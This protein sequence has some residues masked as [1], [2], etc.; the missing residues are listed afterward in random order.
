[1]NSWTT[2]ETRYN[3]NRWQGVLNYQGDRHFPSMGMSFHS[4]PTD[5]QI[6][7]I[8]GVETATPST[9][10]SKLGSVIRKGPEWY[11]EEMTSLDEY[12]DRFYRMARLFRFSS[13]MA[14]LMRTGGT[15][16]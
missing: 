7:E 5:A 10:G 14:R 15:E 13:N 6:Q 4:V 16:A 9:H 2:G 3:K 12:L 8:T 11:W 1:M